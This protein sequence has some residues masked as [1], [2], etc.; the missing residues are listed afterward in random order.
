M[1][2]QALEWTAPGEPHIVDEE[3]PVD[4][5][6]VLLESRWGAISAGSERVVASGKLPQELALDDSFDDKSRG[7]PLRYGYA[8]V[9]EAGGEPWFSFS[10]HATRH[11]LDRSAAKR[12]PDGISPTDATLY[13]FVETATT[14]LWDGTPRPG[15]A[16]LVL[17]LGLI[18]IL[19]ARF[20]S[21]IV[22]CVVAVEPDPQRRAWAI[23]FLPGVSI[24]SDGADASTALGAYAGAGYHT[25][26]RGFDLVY[27]LS[28]RAAVLEEALSL[29]VFG[30]RVVL[31]SWYGDEPSTLSL[32]GRVHRSRPTIISS[33]VSTIP[34]ELATRFDYDRRARIT[35][36]LIHKLDCG[37]I[38]RRVV[39]F[40][41][42][43]A[44]LG[45]LVSGERFEPWLLVRY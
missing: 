27:E 31:G 34:V 1:R 39:E 22:G 16:V 19:T 12:I 7:F 18:G 13:P 11:V 23:G 38:P 41:D 36:D 44:I 29:C 37:S 2:R 40:A 3:I 33:Q 8:L 15:E 6:A 24:C 45:R 21:T 14:L 25:R 35:W 30:G 17:G 42:L 26:Y 28:G 9:G 4:D 20:L 32:G 5:G 43:P 10:P